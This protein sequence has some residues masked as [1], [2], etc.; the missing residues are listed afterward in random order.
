MVTFPGA[1]RAATLPVSVLTGF[2]GSG[3]TTVLRHILTDYRMARTAVVINEFGEIGLDHALIERSGDG[4]VELK[5]GCVCCTIRGDLIDTLRRLYFRCAKGE[6]ASFDRVVIETTGLADP[7]P[8]LQA[9]IADPILD[10]YFHLEAVITTV[11]AV[12]GPAT[13]DRQIEAVKQAAV[14]DRVLITK[15]DLT[16]P[17][18]VAELALRLQRL[19]PTATLHTVENGVIDPSLLFDGTVFDPARKTASVAAW[20]RDDHLAMS[21]APEHHHDHGH[22]HGHDH[23]H[24]HGAHDHPAPDVTRHDA[25]ISSFAVIRERPLRWDQLSAWL[26]SLIELRGEDL[27]RFKGIFNLVESPDRPI[28]V[29][30]VQGIVHPPVALAAWPDADRRSRLV[31]ITRDIDRSVIDQTLTLFDVEGP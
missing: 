8:I 5:S 28:V 11:D 2:L 14:A 19:N 29:H 31:F 22:G 25:H 23:N 12:N 26:N 16:Q 3:K 7:A 9:L 18:L 21:A 17:A 13:L 27:L 24:D 30:G 20:L 4:F 1:D 15:S 6:I 10:A